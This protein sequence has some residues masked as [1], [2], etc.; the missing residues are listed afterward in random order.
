VSASS[1]R[2]MRKIA[3]AAVGA[4]LAG[5]GVAGWNAA[6]GSFDWRVMLA[7]VIGAVVPVVLGYLTP[8]RSDQV[9]ATTAPPR[10]QPPA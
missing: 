10:E 6:D 8:E 4:V 2:P 5:G 7:A 1:W 3:A 9:A